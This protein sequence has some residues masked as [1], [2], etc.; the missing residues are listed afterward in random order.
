MFQSHRQ[1]LRPVTTAH[2]AQ[3]MTLLSLTVDEL[4]QE[5]DKELAQNPALEMA[6]ERR[7]PMC[8]RVL[9]PKGPCPICSTSHGEAE[10]EPVV[11]ISPREDFQYHSDNPDAE[12]DSDETTS[13]EDD[14]P[15]Y[16]LRQISPEL[17]N[18]DRKIAA[19]ILLNL[20]D[21][22]FLSVSIASVAQY[23]HIPLSRVQTIQKIIQHADPIGV[24]SVNTQEALLVQLEV[25]S[26]NHEIPALAKPIIAD[27]MDQLSRRHFSDIARTLRV[28]VR[29]VEETVHFISE[30]LNPFPA[31]SHWGDHR[32]PGESTNLG[33][34]EPDIIITQMNDKPDSPLVVEI[35]L[36]ICGTLRINPLF[37]SA[38]QQ[39]TDEKKEEWKSDLERASL[40][41]KCLQQRNHTILRL[42]KRL[43]TL[44]KDFILNGEKYLRPLTRAYFS[45]E[46]DVHE[47]T[48]S[49]AVSGKTV[50]LPNR[51]IVPLDKFFD[52]SLNIRTVLRDIISEEKHPLSDAELVTILEK[53]GF[54]VARRTVAKYRAM[55]NILPAHLRQDV[56]KAA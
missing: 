24:G 4:R 55:E 6:E 39:A 28:S 29:E 21:D 38:V 25:L 34:R 13:S 20:D 47:S 3:T 1:V 46:L 31:R 37:K 49:R 8:G 18:D 23:F 22:G 19:Y 26:E 27:H 7:C 9:A 16:V 17:A 56:R 50:Q 10:N 54:S 48:I 11:F 42:I 33:Y 32:Q 36:P 51:R 15:T 52:R 53:E 14:L 43:V 12:F 40:F 35:V 30:N 5:I 2:L 45:T 44:Q 41:V